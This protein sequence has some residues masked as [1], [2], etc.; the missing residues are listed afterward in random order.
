LLVAASWRSRSPKPIVEATR[1]RRAAFTLLVHAYNEVRAAIVCLRR[2]RGDADTIVP[3]LHVGRAKWK[4][5]KRTKEPAQTESAPATPTFTDSALACAAQLNA[6]HV[7][8]TGP[9]LQ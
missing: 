9:F 1:N 8:V 5:R 3:A 6:D 4:G 2:Q 7:A